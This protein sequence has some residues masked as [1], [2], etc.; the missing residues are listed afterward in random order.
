[1]EKGATKKRPSDTETPGLPL[2]DVW[3]I[4]IIAGSAKER[5]GYPTQKPLALLERVVVASS[6]EGDVVLDPFCGCGTTIDAA[7]KLGRQWIGIDITYLAINL[8]KHR[9][10][11]TYGEK[12]NDTYEVVGEPTSVPDARVLAESD[13]YQFQWWALGLVGARPVEQKKGADKGIDGR[14]YFHEDGTRTR[15]VVLSIKAGKMKMGYVRDLIAVVEREKAEMGVLISMHAPTKPMRAEAADAAFYESAWGKHP[16]IQLL[17]I[18]DLL[19]GKRI[20]MPAITRSNATFKQA[21]KYTGEG[22]AKKQ[23]PL[24]ERDEE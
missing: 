20:D 17:T 6:N 23:L 21:A 13:P 11:N 10:Q 12:I 3:E 15:Q 8:I 1:M 16:K 24:N 19:S 5:L 22:T 4:S 7:E 2:R 18:P 14:L 9:L